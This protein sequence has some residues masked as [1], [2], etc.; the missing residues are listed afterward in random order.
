MEVR[1]TPFMPLQALTAVVALGLAFYGW[2]RRSTPG[3]IA[4]VVLMLAQ[5]EW[6][7]CDALL[8]GGLND[9]T[10]MFWDKLSFIGLGLVTISFLVFVLQFT[11]HTVPRRAFML[12][13]IEPTITAAMIL[14]SRNHSLFYRFR[15]A[16]SSELL[17]GL[18]GLG[19]YYWI[20]IG[21]I[22]LFLVIAI[23]VLVGALVRSPRLYRG[24]I[25]TLLIGAVIPG[26]TGIYDLFIGQEL[27]DLRVSCMSLSLTG[28]AF[29]FA[30]F[31]YRVLDIVPAARDRVV[32]SMNQSLIV[33]DAQKRIVDLNPAAERL[34]ECYSS[35]VIGKAAEAVLPAWSHLLTSAM[36]QSEVRVETILGEE[37]SERRYILS[38][39]VLSD[40][41]GRFC[42]FLIVLEDI[43]ELKRVQEELQ[44]AKEAAEAA[45][46]AKSIFLAN[47]SHEFRTP[48]NAIIGYSEML[49][50]QAEEVGRQDSIGDLRRIKTAGTH[51]LQL[52]DSILDLSKIEAG[53][54]DLYLER[55]DIAQ[56]VNDIA[57]LVR[58]LIAKNS[59]G[60]QVRC[61]IELGSMRADLTKLRQSLFNLLSN[62][63]KFTEQG[64]V[65]L[66]VER[67]R[68]KDGEWITFRV[69]DTGIG[70]T[71]EELGRIFESFSQADAST[72]RRFGGTGLGLAITRRF[73]Q[74]MGGEITVESEI[75]KGTTFTFRLPAEAAE[76]RRAAAHPFEESALTE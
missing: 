52:I 49:Q 37:G 35:D 43:T 8:M 32:E 36:D 45:N 46:Q 64:M 33:L 26:V 18:A 25:R 58:P 1:F 27:G 22:Y 50:E 69:S 21:Y 12:L 60:L 2:R 61:G 59:N 17:P 76:S 4:F 54:M 41:R 3:A 73:C 57:E 30:L 23:V 55:F 16:S 56:M 48:L 9:S 5:V 6:V 63:S 13:A 53:K 70:M 66:E 44:E 39:S 42:G 51:L 47:M 24:Q 68:G 40:R 75:G 29:G 71:E 10:R 31:R 72:R 34:L 11:G 14:T 62:A 38:L 74:M 67:S 28:L 19:T 7:T 15:D 65:L 20:N